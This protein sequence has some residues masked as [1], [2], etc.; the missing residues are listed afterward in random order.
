MII[1]L[2]YR[3][4]PVLSLQIC[5]LETFGVTWLTRHL[6]D[7]YEPRA[8]CYIIHLPSK[9]HFDRLDI[10]SLSSDPCGA[11]MAVHRRSLNFCHP[12]FTGFAGRERLD[13]CREYSRPSGF[14]FY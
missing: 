5:L 2:S 4:A 14:L 12:F 11:C 3:M 1:S 6:D 8:S 7:R 10:P 9:P 13:V